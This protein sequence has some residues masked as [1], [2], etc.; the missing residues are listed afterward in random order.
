MEFTYDWYYNIIKLLIEKGYQFI[1]YE[2]Y[3]NNYDIIKKCCILRHDID[4]SMK[5]I[6]R[7][8]EVEANLGVFSTWFIQ[9][10]SDFYNPFSKKSLSIINKIL[11]KGGKIGLHFD[12]TSYD[13]FILEN[14]IEFKSY[15]EH[16]AEMLRRGLGGRPIRVVSM[17]RPSKKT[18]DAD[19]QFDTLVN[20]YSKKYFKDFKYI[21][22]SRMNWRE[23]VEEIVRKG[24]EPRLHILTHPFWYNDVE[25]NINEAVIEFISNAGKERYNILNEN[26]TDLECIVGKLYD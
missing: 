25:K 8:L 15:V 2:D 20:S 6:E 24:I 10:N 14:P 1:S 3:E 13:D 19:F 17:H 26:I 12:E 5:K 23:P 4:Y 18:L 9:Y 16:E 22:D 7:M 11:S 21:S